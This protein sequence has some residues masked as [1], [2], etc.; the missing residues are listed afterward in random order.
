METAFSS[1]NLFGFTDANY[2]S[3]LSGLRTSASDFSKLRTA[4][5]AAEDYLLQHAVI[6]PLF[7]QES[8]FVTSDDTAGIYFYSSEDYV[9][10]I[11]ATKK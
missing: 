4:C 7:Y 1:D 3:M 2:T 10:F 9:Y 8:Y 11:D 5:N 6:L